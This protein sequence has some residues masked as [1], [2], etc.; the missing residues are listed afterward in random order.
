MPDF[1]LPL[2]I[3]FFHISS[4]FIFMAAETLLEISPFP[5]PAPPP[6]TFYA[7][8]FSERI[9]RW[10]SLGETRFLHRKY[11]KSQQLYVS[12]SRSAGM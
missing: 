3:T 7:A 9:T 6:L 8:P 1:P 12:S 2:A 5:P 4:S 11:P 10:H